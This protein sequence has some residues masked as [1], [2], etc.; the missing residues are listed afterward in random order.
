MTEYSEGSNW[1]NTKFCMAGATIPIERGQRSNVSGSC[2][3]VWLVSVFLFPAQNAL[4]Y[5]SVNFQNV[6]AKFCYNQTSYEFF[7]FVII[8]T[9]FCILNVEYR[10][11]FR[12]IK[13]TKKCKKSFCVF[14]RFMEPLHSGT[15][16]AVIVNKVKERLPRF[17]RSQSLMVKGSYDFV[18]LNY[19]TSTYAANIP[20]P[21][22][23]PTVFTDNCVRFTSKSFY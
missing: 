21:R 7:L 18:G 13:K 3:Y 10:G 2:F 8:K 9:Q 16:P 23:K 14:S 12:F 6:P 11:E 22:G 15:Y 4:V 17:S 19:Y 20:C 1:S 5:S